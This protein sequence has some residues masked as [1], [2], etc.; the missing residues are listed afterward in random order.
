V[1]KTL[2]QSGLIYVGIVKWLV[3][4]QAD[5]DD[6]LCPLSE[7][8]LGAE[9]MQPYLLQVWQEQVELQAI[10]Y[11]YANGITALIANS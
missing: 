2:S 3:L 7:N 11:D 8:H 4:L 6:Y 10:I 5:E 9:A 1:R